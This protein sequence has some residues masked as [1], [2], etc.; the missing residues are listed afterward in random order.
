[1]RPTLDL[2]LKSTCCIAYAEASLLKADLIVFLNVGQQRAI[3]RQV[4][5]AAVGLPA[6]GVVHTSLAIN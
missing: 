1:M 4:Q 3:D 5:S 6:L 2:L